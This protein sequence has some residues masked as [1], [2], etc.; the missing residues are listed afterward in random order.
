M[1][2]F[3]WHDYETWGATPAVDR[4][5]QFA[6]VRT[7]EQLNIIGEPLV[8]YCQPPVDVLPNPEACLVTGIAPQL[9][10]K[11]GLSER[12]FIAKVHR[13]LAKP[14]T[15]GV[16]YNTIRFDDEVTRYTLFRNFYDPYERE[17]RSGNSRWDIIDMVR[18]VY[19]LRPEGIEWPMVDGK[20]SFK[21]ENLT[22]AN[23]I[24]HQSAHD[25][26]SDVDAT[27]KM[28]QLIKHKKPALYEYVL[29]NRSKKAV[30]E[31][32]DIPR[33]KPLLHISSRFPSTRGCAGLI[34]PLAMHPVNKN[35]VIVYDLAVDPSPL[36]TLSAEQIRER[37]F[38]AEADLP[39]GVSRLPVKLVHLN[40]CPVLGTTKLLDD[41]AAA[42]HGIDK[43]QCEANWQM[44]RRMNVGDKL[45]DMYRLDNFT[46]HEDPETRLYDGFIGADDKRLVT[47]VRKMKAPG[48]ADTTVIFDDARLNE[49]FFR[50]RARN[51][52]ESL[53]SIEQGQW[54]EFVFERLTK[55]SDLTLS[56]D[57]L[58]SR[59]AELRESISGDIA[60]NTVL[61]KLSDYAK[62]LVAEWAPQAD[63]IM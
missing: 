15:C 36:A 2:T 17:W 32:I 30:S 51:Y 41:Q 8:I 60:K 43:A 7:D 31:L 4:P 46:P 3:Y 25:A 22:D 37:V 18:L 13:E 56:Y 23:G 53:S 14:G 27:I 6:G 5:S 47:E 52:P 49:L 44:L 42:R 20:P 62:G 39:E 58:L 63:K 9:A 61:D 57:Q 38:V 1:K 28:A 35:A 11:E 40:K 55:G 26:Y 34:A 10:L 54:R 59:I 21:L 48:F 33:C 12:A 29:A 16:G 45:A 24:S 50:Y 19:A